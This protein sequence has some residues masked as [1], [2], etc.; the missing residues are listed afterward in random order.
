MHRYRDQ[1]CT[2]KITMKHLMKMQYKTSKAITTE[3]GEREQMTR[4]L[5]VVAL[6]TSQCHS[7]QS[8]DKMDKMMTMVRKTMTGNHSS[9]LGEA[10][11]DGAGEQRGEEIAASLRRPEIMIII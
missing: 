1:G 2:G 5:W 6:W 4:A 8:D 10:V 9:G 11:K 7:H 3:N